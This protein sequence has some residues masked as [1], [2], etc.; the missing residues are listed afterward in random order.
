MRTNIYFELGLHPVQ[1]PAPT[2]A[3]HWNGLEARLR[4]NRGLDRYFKVNQ[5]KQMLHLDR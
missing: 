5:G 3:K 2:K 4:W 1:R